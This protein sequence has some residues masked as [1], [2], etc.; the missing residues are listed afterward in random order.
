MI[1]KRERKR[2]R[3]HDSTNSFHFRHGEHF[4]RKIRGDDFRL[5]QDFFQR[6]RQVTRSRGKIDNVFRIPTGNDLGCA[7]T[8]QKI[9]TA[10]QDMVR[11]VVSTRNAAEHGAYRFG[12]SVRGTDFEEIQSA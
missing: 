6:E 7:F 12:I 10:T 8:P 3:N 1:G 4:L 2:I 9:A 5:R 11:E